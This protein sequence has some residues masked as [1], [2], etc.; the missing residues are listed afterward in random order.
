MTRA[1]TE[2]LKAILA[3]LR[4]LRSALQPPDP[5]G[6]DPTGTTMCSTERAWTPAIDRDSGQHRFGFGR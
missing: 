1:E 4:S 5:P 3:E 2:L 6:H